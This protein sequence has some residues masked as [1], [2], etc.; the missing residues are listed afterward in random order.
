MHAQEVR[1]TPMTE[2]ETKNFMINKDNNLL[3]H[4]GLIDEKGEPNVSLLHIILTISPTR[5]TL[6]HLRLLRKFET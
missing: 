5:S 4:V 6:I 2:K 1:M 3:I